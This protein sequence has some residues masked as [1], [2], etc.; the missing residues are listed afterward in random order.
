MI[1]ELQLETKQL[2][3]LDSIANQILNF[4]N[5]RK[6]FAFYGEMGVGKTTLIKALCN[7]L[8]VKDVV[9][10]PT[11]TIVNQYELPNH[12]SVFHFDFYRIKNENEAYDLGY[13][14]YFF[15]NNFCFI[16]WPEKVNGLIPDACVEIKINFDSDKRII[17][18]KLK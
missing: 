10:S 13:E 5:N 9:N 6:V 18:C 2:K 8:G 17:K 7:E 15:D 11:Y 12:S 16:E 3:D 14:D 1:S 4:A